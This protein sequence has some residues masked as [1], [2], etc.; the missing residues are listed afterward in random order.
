MVSLKTMGLNVA[1]A[2]L[3]Y[4]L[5]ILVPAAVAVE[6]DPVEAIGEDVFTHRR[7]LDVRVGSVIAALGVVAAVVSMVVIQGL[8][9]A[10]EAKVDRLADL[11]GRNGLSIQSHEPFDRARLGISRG[12]P[13]VDDYLKVG[14]FEEQLALCSA[15]LMTSRLNVASREKVVGV[16]ARKRPS[17]RSCRWK[18]GK[19]RSRW[20]NP[21]RSWASTGNSGRKAGRY[22]VC[23]VR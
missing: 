21:S 1:V 11:A 19:W 8:G 6:S 20:S 2:S 17:Y 13:T 22:S 4:L 23:P 9:R 15:Y 18:T 10:T 5:A 12:Y 14:Q 7:F 16:P 3:A